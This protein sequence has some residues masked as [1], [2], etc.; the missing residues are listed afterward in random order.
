MSPPRDGSGS[1][2]GVGGCESTF[3]LAAGLTFAA[4][5]LPVQIHG[6]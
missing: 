1:V 5:L 2:G 6:W 4:A 3:K